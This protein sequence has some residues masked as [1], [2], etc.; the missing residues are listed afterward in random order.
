[1]TDL[2]NERLAGMLDAVDRDMIARGD[3]IGAN[4]ARDLLEVY[5]AYVE[6]RTSQPVAI[7][8][9]AFCIQG[10]DGS[11]YKVSFGFE[12]MDQ[13]HAFVDA[14]IAARKASQGEPVAVKGNADDQ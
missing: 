7:P 14:V 1:M 6:H 3:R 13:G 11:G 2:S 8:G 9:Y 5:D 10:R 12:T 4:L